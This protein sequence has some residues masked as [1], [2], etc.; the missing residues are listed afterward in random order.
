MTDATRELIAMQTT[1]KGL[2]AL[3][4]RLD[5]QGLLTRVAA[6]AIVM[7]AHVIAGRGAV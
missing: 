2:Q 1:A 4:H 6:A 5:A 7:R 3:R